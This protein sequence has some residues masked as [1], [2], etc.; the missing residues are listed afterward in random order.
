MAIGKLQVA[1]CGLA[2]LVVLSLYPPSAV[3]QTYPSKTIKIIVPS[4]A[5]G[6]TDFVGRLAADYIAKRSGQIVVVENRPGA[7]GAV[8]MEAVAKSAP[9]GYT[10]GAANTGDIIGGFLH[11]RLSFDPVKDLAPVAMFAKAPQLLVV[12][13][14][15]PAKNLQEFIADAKA[16][17]GQINYGSAGTGSLTQIG[18][19]MFARLAGIKIVHVPY[20]GAIP[21]IRDMI[22]GRVQMMHISLK[23]TYVH[24]KAGTL[25]A[26]AVT[27]KER[28]TEFLPDVP[29]T[30]EAGLPDYLMDIWFG[31]V[32]PR[33]TPKPVLDKVNGYMR[34]MVADPVMRERIVKSFLLPVSMSTDEFAAFVKTDT[35]RWEKIIQESGAKAD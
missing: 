29:T 31:L 8:G 10:L 26:L 25:R 3:A 12:N 13:A 22:S 33:G 24:I 15:V 1:W 32:A 14:K 9:D 2:A 5:G 20:R 30:A 35:P 28:W 19:E 34:E 23:P 18:A 7:G 11:S 4:S 6:I 17:P 27:A 16:R 21:A